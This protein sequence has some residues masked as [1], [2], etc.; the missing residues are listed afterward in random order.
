MCSVHNLWL[1]LYKVG[2]TL[3]SLRMEHLSREVE[4]PLRGHRVCPQFRS[5]MGWCHAGTRPP[6]SRLI[7]PR[8]PSEDSQSE[9][10]FAPEARPRG[11]GFAAAL[12]GGRRGRGINATKQML[13]LQSRAQR[14]GFLLWAAKPRPLPCACSWITVLVLGPLHLTSWNLINLHFITCLIPRLM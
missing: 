10:C 6:P 1:R 12:P 14:P 9:P 7:A 3:S 13:L 11:R 8:F 2:L 5:G 4:E